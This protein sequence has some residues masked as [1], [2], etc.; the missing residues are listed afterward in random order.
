MPSS[1][2]KH[3]LAEVAGYASDHDFIDMLVRE[4]LEKDRRIASLK[5]HLE[6]SQRYVGELLKKLK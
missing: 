2:S 5:Q 6:D 3:K 4:S 1:P